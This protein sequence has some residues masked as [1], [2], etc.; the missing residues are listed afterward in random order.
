MRFTLAANQEVAVKYQIGA[1]LAAIAFTLLPGALLAGSASETVVAKEF[2]A[3]THTV[4]GITRTSDVR[5]L[6]HTA[7]TVHDFVVNPSL[8]PPGP[9]R[10]LAIEWNLAVFQNKPASRFDK[11]L[12]RASELGITLQVERTD[13]TSADGA[14]EL[15]KVAPDQ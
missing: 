14:F 3:D 1:A 2:D 11:L 15:V 13:T 9:Y 8:F 6:R 12:S 5:K 10:S 4:T 7:A